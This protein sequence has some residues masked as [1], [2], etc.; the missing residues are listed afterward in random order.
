MVADGSKGE[1]KGGGCLKFFLLHPFVAGD[2][3]AWCRQGAGGTDGL[4]IEAFA[5]YV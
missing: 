4:R 3:R 1:I 5:T 2:Q